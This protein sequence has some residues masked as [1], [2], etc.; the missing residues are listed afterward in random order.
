MNEKALAHWGVSRLKQTKSQQASFVFIWGFDFL[1]SF[2]TP[3]SLQE[4]CRRFRQST[5]MMKAAR[6]SKTALYFYQTKQFQIQFFMFTSL[7]NSILAPLLLFSLPSTFWSS[8]AT[9]LLRIPFY[10]F[11][12]QRFFILLLLILI[13]L[14]LV[15]F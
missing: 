5:A 9:T 11:P 8:S 4:L 10:C 1:R 3:C 14:H 12:L 2:P 6:S 15:R 13:S 7:K